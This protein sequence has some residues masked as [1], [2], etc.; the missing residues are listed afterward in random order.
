VLKTVD[1]TH[2]RLEALFP[3]FALRRK[4]R[5]CG[6]ALLTSLLRQEAVAG[7]GVLAAF[8]KSMIDWRRNLSCTIWRPLMIIP[9]QEAVADTAK[10]CVKTLSVIRPVRVPGLFDQYSTAKTRRDFN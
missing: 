10:F 2:G 9:A 5:H 1:C 8:R 7:A 3:T 6:V 4:T